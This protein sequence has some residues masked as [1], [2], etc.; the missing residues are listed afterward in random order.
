M[1]HTSATPTTRPDPAPSPLRIGLI[2]C[3]RLGTGFYVPAIAAAR[4]VELAAI[5]EPDLVRSLAARKRATDLGLSEPIAHARAETLVASRSVD[6]VVIAGPPQSH[7]EHAR[8]AAAAGLPALVEKP[9]AT[10]LAGAV[11][12][13][14]LDPAP[15]VGF[16]RRF[17]VPPEVVSPAP[18][19]PFELEL[20][21][22]YLRVRWRPHVTRQDALADVGCHLVD[23]VLLAL[24]EGSALTLRATRL[25]SRRAEAELAGGRGRVRIR[26]ATD[27]PWRERAVLSHPGSGRPVTRWTAGGLT[28]GLRRRLGGI[29]DPLL[30]SLIAQL[31]AFTREVVSGGSSPARTHAETT[32][33]A[34]ATARE[35]VTVMA[36]IEA[37]RESA[38]RGGEWLEPEAPVDA[39]TSARA[40]A[41]AAPGTTP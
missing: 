4:G 35:G 3:G 21:L 11:A 31:E 17:M 12:L 40:A 15:W 23:L 19:E 41:P 9:P 16:N 27:R 1:S 6:A 18:G 39:A 24:G 5:A 7:L 25:E 38:A 34:P 37:L 22:A 28:W 2:G 32:A 33:S 20:G 8:L 13:S 29:P 36:A 10:D 30:G 26:C 14:R